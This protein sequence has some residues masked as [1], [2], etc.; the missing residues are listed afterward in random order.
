MEE[1]EEVIGHPH[2]PYHRVDVLE[3]SRQVRVTL[4][5]EVLAASDR[6]K[7]LF[8]TGL[9]PR[10]YLP[11]EDVRTDLL[12]PSDT[13]TICPY[14]GVASYH[15]ALV[16]GTSIEDAAWLYPEPLPE[17]EKVKD[18]L[19]FDSKKVEVKVDGEKI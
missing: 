1:D 15:S 6:P 17:A 2:D 8:E 12:L 14:K 10:H 4:D 13:E 16:N 18:H 9:P 11:P 19:C 3:S 7:I 5:G